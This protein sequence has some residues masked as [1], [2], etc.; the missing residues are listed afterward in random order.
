VLAGGRFTSGQVAL[1]LRITFSFISDRVLADILLF[2]DDT[3]S[4]S[5]LVS[6]AFC[7][8]IVTNR[9]YAGMDVLSADCLHLV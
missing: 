8:R 1:L 3:R 2:N 6:D 9:V 5:S 4:A 7:L